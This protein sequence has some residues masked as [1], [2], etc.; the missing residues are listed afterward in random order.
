LDV[1]NRE[2]F[3]S[4]AT[5]VVEGET[6]VGAMPLF[7]KALEKDFDKWGI[8]IVRTGK[9][10]GI[11]IKLLEGLNIPYLVVCDRDALMNIEKNIEW[12]GQKVKT[13]PVF[14][15]LSKKNMLNVVYAEYAGKISKFE[16]K[17]SRIDNKE[18]Y[19]DELFNKLSALSRTY[20]IYVLPSDFEGVMERSGYEFLLKEAETISDSKV[21]RGR[22]VAQEIL[23]QNLEV[24]KEFVDVIDAITAR[25]FTLKT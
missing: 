18:V 17:I 14:Y 10:F 6:E 7:S 22:F 9:H 12:N 8:S 24:P 23:K 21:T 4:R 5:L 16:S 19:R 2:I 3:F 11:F 1:Y 13:S 15:N 25:V 20:G